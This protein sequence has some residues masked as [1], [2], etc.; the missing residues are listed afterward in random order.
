MWRRTAWAVLFGI[1][2]FGVI[3]GIELRDV[4]AAFWIKREAPPAG[5]VSKNT[6][7]VLVINSSVNEE[8]GFAGKSC[9]CVVWERPSFNL[10]LNEAAP[11]DWGQCN[12]LHGR[13]MGNVRKISAYRIEVVSNIRSTSATISNLHIEER[14]SIFGVRSLERQ[15]SWRDESS[16]ALNKGPYL[17]AGYKSQQSGERSDGVNLPVE[18]PSRRWLLVVAGISCLLSCFLSSNG[19]RIVWVGWAGLFGYM[20]TFA[21][22]VFGLS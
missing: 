16:L 9:H 8:F 2:V 3:A 12:L 10:E 19:D 5:F 4:R 7:I 20:L 15:A 22:V 17:N 13:V 1:S 6:E 21:L 11:N 18:M 14:G